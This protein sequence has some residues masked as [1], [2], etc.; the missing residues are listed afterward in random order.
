MAWVEDVLKGVK[1]GEDFA[2]YESLTAESEIL[3]IVYEGERVEAHR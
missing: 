1:G 3:G 2:G